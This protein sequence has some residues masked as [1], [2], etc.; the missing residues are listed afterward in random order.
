[1]ATSEKDFEGWFSYALEL[2]NKEPPRRGFQEGEVWRCALGHNVGHELDGKSKRY[3]RPVLILQKFSP[4]FFLGVPLSKSSNQRP[5][6]IPVSIPD[7]AKG[8]KGKKSYLVINQLRAM[9][10][11][12]LQQLLTQLSPE[13]LR[14]ARTAIIE[15]L[16]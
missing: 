2:E 9:D 1:M 5:F 14:Y 10:A 13:A 6:H 11:R 15:M 12:R 3:W 4:D 16:N 7:T 8:L